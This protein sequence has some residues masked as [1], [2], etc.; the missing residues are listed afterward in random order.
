MNDS[1]VVIDERDLSFLALEFLDF[2]ILN[3]RSIRLLCLPAST[4]IPASRLL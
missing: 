1:S 4:K 3:E 2:L